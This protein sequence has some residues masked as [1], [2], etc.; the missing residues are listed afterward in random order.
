ML[1][2][3]LEYSCIGNCVHLINSISHGAV[4]YPLRNALNDINDDDNETKKRT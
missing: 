1:V 3:A 2:K 4:V